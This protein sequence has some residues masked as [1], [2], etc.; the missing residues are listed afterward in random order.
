MQFSSF[1]S[2]KNY[3]QPDSCEDSI[4]CLPKQN[5]FGVLDGIGSLG[6]EQARWSSQTVAQKLSEFFE[7]FAADYSKKKLFAESVRAVEKLNLRLFRQ[8]KREN[9]ALGTTLTWGVIDSHPRRPYLYYGLIGDSPLFIYRQAKKQ[10]EMVALTDNAFLQS[11]VQKK[12]LTEKQAMS[13]DNYEK[14]HP[15]LIW[16]KKHPF[17][18]VQTLA[19]EFEKLE[20]PG[21]MHYLQKQA[22]I[23]VWENWPKVI[24]RLWKLVKKYQADSQKLGV[25]IQ[26][27]PGDLH[28]FSDSQKFKE[29]L[30]ADFKKGLNLM[31]FFY[32]FGLFHAELTKIV[33]KFLPQTK[34]VPLM[35]KIVQDL[36]SL[37][38]SQRH[39]LNNAVGNLEMKITTGKKRLYPGDIVILETDGVS[40]LLT[41]EEQKLVVD[42][43]L[44]EGDFSKLADNLITA[45]LHKQWAI[46][47]KEVESWRG[48]YVDDKAVVAVRV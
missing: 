23:L 25:K 35:Q 21:P 1:F 41:E 12:V 37:N 19:V 8:A 44:A 26:F 29:V 13:L 40:D 45:A 28:T 10:L 22:D 42:T 30:Q 48:K 17:E 7:S 31:R 6:P 47:Q 46:D 2:A 24:N 27:F 39:I 4:I 16:L 32:S 5:S 14:N 9:L 20:Y 33:V 43:T 18:V 3:S 15:L 36:A 11:L 38:F 34:N